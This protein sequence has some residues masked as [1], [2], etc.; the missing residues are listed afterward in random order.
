MRVGALMLLD[1]RVVLVKHR[2]GDATY[3][4][5]P[6][7]GVSFGET[8]EHALVR[9]VAEETGLSCVL[10]R[11]LVINDT[12]DPG[13]TRHIVNLTFLARIT[14]GVVTGTPLDPRVEA[15]ETFD[16]DDLSLLD[17][18]PPLTAILQTALRDFDAFRTTYAGSPY[19][20]ER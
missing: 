10:E 8:I 19:V 18:R 17:L 14:G 2:R 12:I 6:G 16:P 4:L 20:Q 1:G 7:G 9:E 15:V 11:P 3:Y 13:G 5:L